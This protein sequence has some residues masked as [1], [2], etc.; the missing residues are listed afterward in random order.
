MMNPLRFTFALLLAAPLGLAARAADLV[1]LTG[2]KTAGTLVAVTPQFVEFEPV[3]GAAVKVGVK[4]LAAVDLKNKVVPP[5]AGAKFDEVELTDG[6]IIRA[7][8]LKVK[9]KKVELALLTGAAGAAPPTLDLPLGNVFWVMRSA[10]DP[11]ARAEWKKLVSARGKRD[12][13]VVRQAAGYSPLPGT[14]IEG[15]AAG[16]RV[17]FEREDGVRASLPLSRATGGLVFNQPPRDAIAPTVCKVLDVFGNV[18][19]AQAVEVAGSGLKVKTI[20]GAT[21]AY[22]ALASVAKLDFSQGNVAYLSDLEAVA[23]YPPPETDGPLGEQ[24][25]FAVTYQKDRPIGAAEI[26]LGG[27]KFAKG[28]SVPPDTTL[29]YKLDG[30]YREFKAVTGI[31]DGVKPD[32]GALKLRIEV[33]GRAVFNETVRKKDKPRAINLN[34]KDAKELKITVEREALFSG[35][36]I[37]LADARVQK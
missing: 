12:L 28:I 29:T 16:D 8:E 26:V 34:V 2:K 17:T 11:K 5:G 10:H 27:R 23:D 35:N 20:S 36:Q 25:P 3:A 1:T 18:W 24:F 14:V 15:N 6:S 30:D 13:F 9:G 31:L 33:D 19:F 22:P 7:T 21:V 4:E 32:D 37:N